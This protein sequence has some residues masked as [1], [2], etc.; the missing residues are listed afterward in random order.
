MLDVFEHEQVRELGREH[1]FETQ[2]RIVKDCSSDV[3]VVSKVEKVG[4]VGVWVGDI[5]HSG[6]L[7]GWK[8]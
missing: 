8:S 6:S 1:F 4:V 7:G 2:R 3:F 5:F